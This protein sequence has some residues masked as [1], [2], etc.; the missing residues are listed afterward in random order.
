LC[1][2]RHANGAN[3]MKRLIGPAII[4]AVLAIAPFV[5]QAQQNQPGTGSS[6]GYGQ[7]ATP[8]GGAN[9]GGYGQQVA[10]PGSGNG[11]GYGEQLN[12]DPASPSPRKN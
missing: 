1:G 5:A 6:G 3:L 4:A 11:G 12:K 8:P 7:Q 9:G 2:E 10:P